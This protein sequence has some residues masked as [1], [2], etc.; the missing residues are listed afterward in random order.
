M[1]AL[2]RSDALAVRLQPAWDFTASWPA[3]HYGIAVIHD[4]ELAT[5]GDTHHVF[6]LASVTKLLTAWAVH[7]ACEE[8]SVR[9][10]DHVGQAGCTV[11]HL[12]AHA[13]GYSFDGDQPI[14]SPESRRIYSNT[15]YELL[16]RHVEQHTGID[17]ATYMYE[18]ICE[19]L[20]MTST[21]LRGSAA[22]DG[23]SNIDDL[24]KFVAELCRPRLISRDTYIRAVTPAFPELAGIVPGFGKS[25]PS[26]WGLGPEIK[27]LKDPH[28]TA[29][30]GATSTFGHFGSVGTF[31]WVDPVANVAVALLSNTPFDDWGPQHWA[32]FNQCV[33]DC[34]A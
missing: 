10:D 24:I 14:A 32:P 28:W 16:S 15:G 4:N 29:P 11:E 27:G 21:T 23:W 1:S 26:L 31:A 7:V 22:K 17:F 5:H 3:Q 6:H 8:G 13:G 25:D 34:C 30:Q 33:L 2:Q 12:L 20:G 19:P 9:L 18:A